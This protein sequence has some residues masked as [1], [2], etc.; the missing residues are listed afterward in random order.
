VR[1]TVVTCP[2]SGSVSTF[3]SL[4]EVVVQM[5]LIPS[6]PFFQNDLKL[7][8]ALLQ[9]EVKE[10]H[11][12]LDQVESLDQEDLIEVWMDLAIEEILEK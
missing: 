5:D 11:E 9:V 3:F 7:S 2:F 8:N 12:L 4:P 1:H 10:F 6:H